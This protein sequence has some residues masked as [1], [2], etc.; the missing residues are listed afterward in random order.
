[1]NRDAE[2][3]FH[4]LAD[5]SPAERESYLRE[6]QISADVRDEVETLLRFDLGISRPDGKRRSL[7][8]TGPAYPS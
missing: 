6:R 3:L 2:I 1:M 7:R 8:G 4:E 5:L